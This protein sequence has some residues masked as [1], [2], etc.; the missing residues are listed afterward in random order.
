[1]LCHLTALFTIFAPLVIWLIKKNESRTVD[2]HGRAV[3]NFELSLLVY[4]VVGMVLFYVAFFA[5]L[6][7]GVVSSNPFAAGASLVFLPVFFLVLLGLLALK[8]ACEITASVRASNGAFF[9]YP[10]AIPFLGR[11][12]P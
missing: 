4:I 7:A 1:M 9:H 8:V 11:P 3:L 5:T 6:A 10:L 12:R 2:A